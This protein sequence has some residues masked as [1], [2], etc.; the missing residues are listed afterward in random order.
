MQSC[1]PPSA[2]HSRNGTGFGGGPRGVGRQHRRTG[3]PPL[4]IEEGGLRASRRAVHLYQP[5]SRATA[6]TQ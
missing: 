2:S 6:N 1:A 3:G 5:V 4:K